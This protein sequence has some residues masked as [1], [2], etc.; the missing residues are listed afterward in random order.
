MFVVF[1]DS[2]E[3]HCPVGVHEF[4]RKSGVQLKI[5]LRVTLQNIPDMDRIYHTLDYTQLVDIVNKEAEKERHLLETLAS[6]IAIAI[7]NTSTQSI[8]NIHIR[9]EKPVIPHEGYA[10]K[11]CGI[12]YS[13]NP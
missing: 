1:L 6:D 10:A 9:I 3:V 13:F 5:S 12:E 4:E 11:A 2:Q 7:Q 8:D